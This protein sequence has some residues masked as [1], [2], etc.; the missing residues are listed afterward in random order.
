M[1]KGATIIIATCCSCL[2]L[3]KDIVELEK[4]LGKRWRRCRINCACS[5]WKTDDSKKDLQDQE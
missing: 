5:P 1:L 2:K 3:E 4:I